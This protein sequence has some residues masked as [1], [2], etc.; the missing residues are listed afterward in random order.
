MAVWA[1]CEVPE[2]LHYDVER[3]VWVRLHDS[4]QVTL[5]MTDIAQARSGKIQHILIKKVGKHLAR[6]RSAATI[7]SAKWAGPFPTPV[8]GTVVENNTDTFLRD[9]RI[10]NRDPYGEGW[11]IRLQP[12]AWD[13]E[14]EDLVTSDE[15]VTRYVARIN[16]LGIHCHRCEE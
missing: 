16:E 4:G 8:S 13:E 7:E 14:S 3:D 15:A 6:G 5:G 2:D 1:G 11:I 12:D 9:V 10:A